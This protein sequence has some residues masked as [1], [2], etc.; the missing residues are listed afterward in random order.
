MESPFIYNKYVT[1]KNF[2]GRKQESVILGNLLSAGE[3]VVIYE[4]PKSGKMSL[5]EQTLFNMRI[6]GKRFCVGDVNLLNIRT[7]QGFLLTLGDAVIRSVA[8]TPS[9]YASIVSE[10][11]A[12]T[13]FVFDNE[14]YSD[15]D[16]II[17]LN[18]DIDE[19]D[20][21]SM[22]EFPYKVAQSRHIDVILLIS[23]FQNI[24]FFDGNGKLVK[25]MESTIRKNRQEPSS[26]HCP[27]LL[28]G[29][30]VNAMKDIFEHRKCF[31]RLVEHFVLEKVDEKD[32]ADYVIR[33]FLSSG[34]VIER[35]LLLDMIRLLGN[36]LWYVNHYI[37]ICDALS[38]GYIMEPLL[39]EALEML[40]SVHEP[41]Y[42]AIMNDLTNFQVSL[43][44]AIVD[45]HVKFSS[46]EVIASYCL[47]SSANVRR[48]KDA[49]CKKEI[50][51]FDENDE[52]HIL[53]PLFE[54]WVKNDYFKIAVR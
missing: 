51:T 49:L 9:E 42:M 32:I 47:N 40:V 54:Y 25:Q 50:I 43:L 18:W 22:L 21:S 31:Y 4:P 39:M 30:Q 52:P 36:N 17:S 37:S 15:K 45:G 16:E 26:F 7:L 8:S 19:F 46:S 41:G 53:D 28:L 33:G 11:L 5:V 23:E 12:G 34:K 24:C 29:S 14:A 27:L 48:L 10:L 35:D 20:V 38:R 1:G 44:R 6:Q 2:I 13:H 3:N